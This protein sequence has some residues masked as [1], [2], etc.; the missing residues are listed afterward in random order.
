MQQNLEGH[1]SDIRPGLCTF[2]NMNRVSYGSTN[3]FCFQIRILAENIH[4]ILNQDKAVGGN[5]IQSSQE[6]RNIA[7]SRPG[8]QKGLVCRENQG[9]IGLDSLL[10]QHLYSFQTFR[11]HRNLHH[12][13]FGQS[14]N[15]P[16]LR[17]HLLRSI[18]VRP[19]FSGDGA[20]HKGS[21]FLQGFLIV[22]TFLGNER[23]I[24]GYTGNDSHIIGFSN[25]R[26]IRC[27]NIKFH[28]FP[29]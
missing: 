21:N 20:I 10:G 6:R 26:Y 7:C 14:G 8:C 19:Y 5:I 23:R 24:S 9:N 18:A 11:R 16:S 28:F 12:H 22:P 2:Q 4:N 25:F 15:L 29:P 27:I 13:I 1:S 3:H 17:N